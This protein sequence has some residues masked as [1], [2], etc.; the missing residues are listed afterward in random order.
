MSAVISPIVG[1]VGARP[2][3]LAVAPPPI[4]A[5]NPF[6]GLAQYQRNDALF[7]RDKDTELIQSRL[8]SSRVTIMFAGSGVGKSSFLNAKLIPSLEQIFRPEH[9][10]VPDANS[11]ARVDPRKALADAKA[12]VLAAKPTRRG[13]IIVLDQFEEVFQHFPTPVLLREFGQELATIAEEESGHNI[14]LLISLR[15]EFLADLTSLDD[16][17][18][19]V[20]SNY[21]RLR[22]L[23]AR[24]AK[25]IVEN[26]AAL[27]GV[28]VDAKVEALVRDLSSLDRGQKRSGGVFIDPPYLQIVCHRVW[29]REHPTGQTPF[30]WSYAEGEAEGELKAYCREKLAGLARGQRAVV[31]KALQHLTGPHEAKKCARVND[32]ACE[33]H[34]GNV[35][36]LVSALDILAAPDTRILRK[37]EE[38]AASDWAQQNPGKPRGVYQLYHDM[39]APMLWQWKE[40]QEHHERRRSIAVTL[41]ISAALLFFVVWPAALRLMVTRPVNLPSYGNADEFSAVLDMRN[42]FGRTMVLRTVGDRIWQHYINKLTT[43]SALKLDM[44]GAI[45]YR[46]A[47]LAS[48]GR[49]A[50]QS[51]VAGA[52]GPA[53]HLAGTLSNLKGAADAVVVKNRG[54]QPVVIIGT[55]DGEIVE[56]VPGERKGK[57]RRLVVGTESDEPG[58][59]A[60]QPWILCLSPDGERAVAARTP[61]KSESADTGTAAA[62]RSDVMIETFSTRTGRPIEDAAVLPLPSPARSPGGSSALE[63][64]AS[65]IDRRAAFADMRASCEAGGARFAVMNAQAAAVFDGPRHWTIAESDVRQAAFLGDVVVL[66]STE[67]DGVSLRL[68]AWRLAVDG[69]GRALPAVLLNLA[70]TSL[71]WSARLLVRDSRHVLAVRNNAWMWIAPAGGEAMTEAQVLPFDPY[72]DPYSTPGQAYGARPPQMVPQAYDAGRDL[73]VLTDDVGR[74]AFSHARRD[75][76]RYSV[77]PITEQRGANPS[78]RQLAEASRKSLASGLVASIDEVGT[79]VRVWRV[80]ADDEPIVAMSVPSPLAAAP[81]DACPKA[82]QDHDVYCSVGNTWVARVPRVPSDR[83]KPSGRMTITIERSAPAARMNAWSVEVD[84][85]SSPRGVLVS[86]TG[87]RIVVML[88]DGFVYAEQITAS[89]PSKVTENVYAAV[90]GPGPHRITLLTTDEVKIY[91][92]A[93]MAA[94]RP[95]WRAPCA[96]LTHWFV[97]KADESSVLLYSRFW[98][99]RIEPSTG[100]AKLMGKLT[101]GGQVWPQVTSVLADAMIDQSQFLPRDGGDRRLVQ[102]GDAVDET[103]RQF[104]DVEHFEGAA[105]IPHWLGTLAVRSCLARAPTLVSDWRGALCLWEGVSGRRAGVGLGG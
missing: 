92:A 40:Q 42:A 4:E 64:I 65:S 39:Y 62:Q 56:W 25:S 47:G 50:A 11:W 99:H 98:T 10:A 104:A 53:R 55:S 69:K 73:V 36:T 19:G 78:G 46:L 103:H 76:L 81:V 18:P 5:G 54:P 43:L 41:G 3:A 59:P 60:V 97:P 72:A 70:S 15:E 33:A 74:I 85:D 26:T 95:E 90:F 58:A 34:I 83:D 82:T 63:Q 89:S 86:S 91:D 14:R 88:N 7:A 96:A 75:P 16:F 31:R 105:S 30:L 32:I 17:L 77:L 27:A 52:L 2:G 61:L 66:A 20:L 57:Y 9:V 51:D 101:R 13:S 21:Y 100:Y 38:S 71:P 48:S 24:Q 102:D 29:N 35:E 49:R 80:P 84:A 68:R 44:D 28:P 6:R 8:W 94:N 22:R 12:Q 45:T 37:W 67:I 79:V 93:S 1:Q 23:T 87:E